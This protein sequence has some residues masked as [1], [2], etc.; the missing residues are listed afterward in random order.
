MPYDWVKREEDSGEGEL[1]L[2]P[3]QS[4]NPKG[5]VLFIGV[6][7]ALLMV[8]LLPLLGSVVLWGILPFMLAALAAMWFALERNRRS[9][10]ILEVFT[11]S[12]DNAHLV[13]RNPRGD[14]QEWDCNRYWARAAL[15]ERDGPVPYYVTLSG[16]GR[17]VEIGAFLSEEERRALFDELSRNLKR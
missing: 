1:H 3:H 10:Q 13:R 16:N 8:P 11:L 7:F 15:H 9:A 5:F 14:I 2:W 4:M 12:G 6:T 17:E